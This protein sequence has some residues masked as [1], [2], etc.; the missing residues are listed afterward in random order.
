MWPIRLASKYDDCKSLTGN[1]DDR[2]LRAY[3]LAYVS[4][5]GPRL[6]NLLLIILKKRAHQKGTQ[7][8]ERS[9]VF[10]SVSVHVKPI[11]L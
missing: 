1:I 9:A 5:I 4:T 10:S 2:L 6:L 3:G 7:T 11:R 8:S